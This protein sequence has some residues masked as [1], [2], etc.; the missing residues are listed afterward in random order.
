MKLPQI[1]ISKKFTAGAAGVI[2]A[3]LAVKYPQYQGVINQVAAVV[4]TYIAGESAVD[5]ARALAPVQSQ[6]F[7][8]GVAQI[9][10]IPAAWSV[11]TK[12]SANL[13]DDVV[14]GTVVEP[15]PAG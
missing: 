2:F 5:I 6:V 8:A 12:A 1:K 9:G 11:G 14:E 7:S 4:S 3:G 10:S 15:T 13:V